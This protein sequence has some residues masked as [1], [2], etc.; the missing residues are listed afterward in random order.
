V[1]LVSGY[2]AGRGLPN[3][4]TDPSGHLSSL[5][6]TP[7]GGGRLAPDLA[8]I[9]RNI[10]FY[11]VVS[12]SFVEITSD[13]YTRNLSDFFR[14]DEDILGW[15][16]D[17]WQREELGHGAQLKNYVHAAW[18]DFDWDAA[19][20]RFF[21][22]FSPECAP[23]A[24]AASRRQELVALCVVE[25]GTASLYRM[26]AEST[27]EPGLRRITTNIANQEIGHYKQFLRHFLRY[28]SREEMSVV[29][30]LRAV[31]AQVTA[32]AGIDAYLAFK[33]VYLSR[34]PGVEFTPSAYKAFR[35]ACR[36]L[37]SRHFP[38]RMA[39]KMLLR[40]LPLPLTLERMIVPP[41]ALS[42]RLLFVMS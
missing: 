16:G 3:G 38:H 21:D 7:T 24:M 23:T 9:E 13:L 8:E 6:S 40:L 15:I 42:T 35:T 29:A 12:A 33:H 19:Y 2:A 31:W 22:E 25:T 4:N 39:V 28:R 10:V 27:H 5:F 34:N 17:V 1:T 41:L 11:I 14:G 36:K 20:Q 37:S 32:I 18:P 30:I 26:L